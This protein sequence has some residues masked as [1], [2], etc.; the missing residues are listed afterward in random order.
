MAV[1]S[2]RTR[3]KFIVI[4]A[5]T[6]MSIGV[7]AC[8]A[9]AAAP[10]SQPS[11]VVELL[12]V[13]A[14]APSGAELIRKIWADEAWLDT[15]QSFQLRLSGTVT[16]P[17]SAIAKNR[18]DLQKQLRGRPIDE[19]KHSE[20]WPVM[21]QQ[22]VLVFDASR[23]RYE[24]HLPFMDQI[25]IWDGHVKS[26]SER[27]PL[28]QQNTSFFNSDRKTEW[29]FSP[30]VWGRTA[31]HHKWMTESADKYVPATQPAT[32][33]TPAEQYEV[34]GQREF[35]GAMCYVVVPHSPRGERLYVGV[36]DHRL[37][38]G[39]SETSLPADVAPGLE[40]RLRARYDHSGNNAKSVEEW[41]YTLPTATRLAY[42]AD[43][44]F[45]TARLG[46]SEGEY[47][48]FDYQQ[49]APGCWFP[50]TQG[51]DVRLYPRSSTRLGVTT[52]RIAAEPFIIESSDS[53]ADLIEVNQPLDPQLF[54][55]EP[56]PDGEEV[57]D[58][59]HKPFLVYKYKHEMTAAEW[60]KA[61]DEADQ[62][63]ALSERMAR[64]AS[65]RPSKAP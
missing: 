36:S 39:D 30:L 20:L 45:E 43:L 17:A 27:Y 13:P 19:S 2:A 4:V 60:Q 16:R 7:L 29:F 64:S 47:W 24:N 49:V 50:M 52:A 33:S 46:V 57:Q 8:V 44:G 14:N 11:S 22:S 34:V 35:H 21:Q 53:Q 54:A 48:M 31:R 63:Q 32:G 26:G 62:R 18:A 37:R 15:V 9:R 51:H 23:Y 65:T 56:I 42:A 3:A 58:G 10:A 61:L 41:L 28:D 59:V 38:G 6:V 40:E 12:P 25:I 1:S 5:T 55:R